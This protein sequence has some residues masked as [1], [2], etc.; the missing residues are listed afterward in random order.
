MAI[1]YVALRNELQNDPGVIG[2][3]AAVAAGQDGTCADALNLARGGAPFSVFLPLLAATDVQGALDP[4]EFATL[5]ATQL[6]QL[7]VMLAGGFVNTSSTSVRTI[8]IGIFVPAGNFAV[9][10]AALTA[11]VKRP[12]SRAEVLF[13]VGTFIT[14]RDVA[15]A[16]GRVA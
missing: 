7:S 8:A 6:S 10:R 16:F 11:L 1:D 12:G 13:G 3:S 4:T 2:Y 14:P 5:S 15:K 9:T